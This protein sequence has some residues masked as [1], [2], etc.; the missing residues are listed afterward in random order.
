MESFFKF[1]GREEELFELQDIFI[2]EIIEQ[3]NQKKCLSYL[4]SGHHGVGK[5]RLIREFL[6]SLQVDQR[7]AIHIP[8]FRKEKHVIEYTCT[9]DIVK[10]YQPFI[11]IQREIE[12]QYKTRRI[13]KN[14]FMLSI[15]WLP[16]NLH[17]MIEDL[18]K[19]REDLSGGISD[20]RTAELEVKTHGKFLK[21]LG[22]LSSK[23]PLILYIQNIQ[24]IDSHSLKLLQSLMEDIKGK[25]LW[26][27]I[28]LEENEDKTSNT[29]I[30]SI[31]R[32]L[33]DSKKLKS[34]VL[35]P[36]NKGYEIKVMEEAF[37]PGLFTSAEFDHIY[38]LSE[39]NPGLLSRIVEEWINKRWIYFS[40]N[41]WKKIEGFENKIKP[42]IK[43]LVDLIIVFL[44]DGEI[45]PR[46]KKLINSNAQEWEISKD[47]VS[48]MIDLVLKCRE[49]GYQIDK[50]VH[51]GS[52][53]QDAFLAL[54]KNGEKL[55]IEYI[56]NGKKL[57]KEIV[58]KEIKHPR[59]LV[60]RDIIKSKEGILIVTNYFEGKTLREMREKAD[61]T[62]IQYVL[63]IAEQIAEGI[64]ELHR[65]GL[66]HGYI[67]PESVIKTSEG[68]IQI[69]AIDASQLNIA[70]L[71]DG[72]RYLNYLSYCSPEMIDKKEI[73]VRSDIFSFGIL[74]FEMLTGELPFK[75]KNKGEI[76]QA[77]RFAILPPFKNIKP[78]IPLSLQ[79]ILSKCLQR[80]PEDRYQTTKEILKDIHELV[81][82]EWDKNDV[83]EDKR[84][85][86]E[87]IKKEI[88]R[89]R[90][91]QWQKV[92][93]SII[94]SVF[95]IVAGYYIIKKIKP[96]ILPV[97]NT[98]VINNI[99][100]TNQSNRPTR[101]SSEMIRY[102][103][104]DDVLQSSNKN[105]ISE[106]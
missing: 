19:L 10:P 63:Q 33:R 71:I 88:K 64:A 38:T 75:G 79:A 1:T 58:P 99:N 11:E 18:E 13:L 5:T 37:K 22:R 74:F 4:I 93:I 80:T 17:D 2:K 45:S 85:N 16:I 30:S 101:L 51:N 100:V 67:C 73:D 78:F 48:N 106:E 42:P 61:E 62:H 29:D 3:K 90:K 36:L 56:P 12:L 40:N 24:W 53:A 84:I 39:G 52:I 26:G 46:E 9:K 105:I 32:R 91:R 92:I 25:K 89:K 97:K 68:E 27:M 66:I 81:P 94:M 60:A 35:K 8:R 70:E 34:L 55:I 76:K 20:D 50:R 15:S 47:V 98:V 28:I 57:E 65:N 72:E 87:E 82:K 69:T 6:N 102:L 31:F 95:T 49:L 96:P 23:T 14:L 104:I 59:L 41:E 21:M 54:D 83:D 86:K 43:K 77:I 44:Q 103:I 7:I